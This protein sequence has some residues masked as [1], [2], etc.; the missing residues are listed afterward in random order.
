MEFLGGMD[1]ET[2]DNKKPLKCYSFLKERAAVP[3]IFYSKISSTKLILAT[4]FYSQMTTGLTSAHVSVTVIRSRLREEE[5]CL[6]GN[7]K[8]DRK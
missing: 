5:L 4:L 8:N 2:Q 7:F 3:Q 1:L 6:I